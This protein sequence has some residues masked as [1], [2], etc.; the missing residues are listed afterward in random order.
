MVVGGALVF[1]TPLFVYAHI[2]INSTPMMACESIDSTDLNTHTGN[3]IDD[4]I[5]A[6]ASST[7]MSLFSARPTSTSTPW[8]RNPLVWTDEGTNL[9][10]TGM[11]PWNTEGGAIQ[12]T[13]GATLISPRHFIAANHYAV[14]VGRI[15]GFIDSSGNHIERTVTGSTNISGTDI[16]VELLDSDVPDSIT[17]YPIMASS[18]LF[19]SLQ[20]VQEETL[21]V[22]IVVFDQESK[23]I[24]QKIT[25]IPNTSIGHLTYSTG[26]RKEF[27]ESLISGDSGQPGFIIVDNQP[28]LLFAHYTATAGPNLG[29]YINQ[30]NSAMT[31]LGGGYQVTEYE[32]TCFTEY[33]LNHYAVWPGDLPAVMYASEATTTLPVQLFDY[34]ATDPDGDNLSYRF[35]M[36]SRLTSGLATTSD[37]G[38]LT[39]SS[40]INFETLQTQSEYNL[41]VEYAEED[42]DN[43]FGDDVAVEAY[44]DQIS[45]FLDNAITAYATDDAM[46]PAE[47]YLSRWLRFY[48]IEEPPVFVSSPY[49]FSIAENSSSGTSIGSISANDEDYDEEISYSIE[50]GNSLGAFQISEST[51]AITVLGASPLDYESRQSI[52]LVVM[53]SSTDNTRIPNLFDKI[54]YATTTV[55]INISDV[56]DTSSGGGGGGVGGGGSTARTTTTVVP[57]TVLVTP[58]INPLLN[59]LLPNTTPNL[60]NLN[61]EIKVFPARSITV[62]GRGEDVKALQRFLNSKG[63][64]V[65]PIGDGSIGKETTYFGLKTRSALARFQASVGIKPA[66]GYFGP[67]TRK[68]ILEH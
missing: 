4:R 12:Y 11:S 61:S 50:S 7:G 24:V 21:D 64:T 13:H 47:K 46:F 10:F 32:P 53:A 66:V 48:N 36:D 18:T 16:Q 2:G 3:Q 51:G 31:S 42:P 29:N 43:I 34:T 38:I 26:T 37:S 33:E 68:Y 44:I 41:L 8:T 17:Y 39:Y 19:S 67:I 49:T 9:N 54:N 63:F 60:S 30:I 52:S 14:S 22:P 62:G 55:T 28:V 15:V 59:N 20:K 6:V 57:T 58:T 23:A 1:S 5:D 27:S 25:Y 35:E 56:S 65:S 40:N 45:Q